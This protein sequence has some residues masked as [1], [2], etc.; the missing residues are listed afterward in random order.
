MDCVLVPC[1]KKLLLDGARVSR[2]NKDFHLWEHRRCS[3]MLLFFLELLERHGPFRLLASRAFS[4][5]FLRSFVV[6]FKVRIEGQ[7]S[8]LK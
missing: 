3:C 1:D 7:S 5:S 2:T 4:C 8:I 6:G